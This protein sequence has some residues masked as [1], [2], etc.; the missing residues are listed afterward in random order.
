MSA[1]EAD[2]RDDVPEE[3][4]DT[5]KGSSKG[6][7]TKRKGKEKKKQGPKRPLSAYMFFCQAMRPDVKR[8]NPTANF[9]DLG[10]LLGAK[11]QTLKDHEKKPYEKQN[12]QDK[13]RYEKEK[14]ELNRKEA[15][16]S[17]DAEPKSK[18]PKTTTTAKNKEKQ[19]PKNPKSA[20]MLFA[21][22]ERTKLKND[23]KEVGFAESGKYIASA[24]AH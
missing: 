1:A 11:W 20:Y 3:D 24:G 15:E 23:G 2:D 8:D 5:K 14:E 7:G 21:D 4:E 16:D 17:G 6:K 13:E 19:G 10:K 18:K 9:S 12:Q 22:A